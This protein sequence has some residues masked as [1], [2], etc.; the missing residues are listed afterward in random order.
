VT[1]VLPFELVEWTLSLSPF[2]FVPTAVDLTTP[3]VP[4]VTTS[5]NEDF[6][7]LALVEDL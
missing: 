1:T 4:T 2:E 3:F 6:F 5:L 7:P